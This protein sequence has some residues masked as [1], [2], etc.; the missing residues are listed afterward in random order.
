MSFGYLGEYT[1]ISIVDYLKSIGQPSDFASR[2][3]LA[4]QNGIEN[5]TG[6]A[7]QNTKLLNIL[8]GGVSPITPTSVTLT[9]STPLNFGKLLI[10]ILMIGAGLVLLV[11][12]KLKKG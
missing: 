7:E 6:S 9:P 2:S 3:I 11:L 5:Y 1:G 4:K 10:P 12:P 8:R